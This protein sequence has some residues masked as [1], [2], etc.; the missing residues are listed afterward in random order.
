MNIE[1]FLVRGDEKD[2]WE[3]SSVCDVEIW[4][5]LEMGMHFCIRTTSSTNYEAF[6]AN[7]NICSK[8]Q[9]AA[10]ICFALHC[11]VSSWSQK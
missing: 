1:V 3:S 2:C 11:V 4:R 7:K 6:L 9:Y 5:L 10:K 8:K